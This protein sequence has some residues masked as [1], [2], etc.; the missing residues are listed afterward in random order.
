MGGYT[1]SDCSGTPTMTSAWTV[2][3]GCQMR[4]THLDAGASYKIS[5]STYAKKSGCTVS[6]NETSRPEPKKLTSLKCRPKTLCPTGVC[7]PSTASA[8]CVSRA[9]DASCPAGHP[10]RALIA[11]TITDTRQ[12]S[13][14]TCGSTLDCKISKIEVH[15]YGDCRYS[16]PYHFS[17][18]ASSCYNYAD[19]WNANA[20]EVFAQNTGSG[21]CVA[22]SASTPSGS[23]ALDPATTETVCC[24]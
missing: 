14:C 2:Q 13:A 3:S 6:S 18:T 10:N 8:V 17:V 22:T 21:A 1:A 19:S 4:P 23:V 12:C 5:G 20:V 9:G 11:T 7:V 24:P 16:V 15:N